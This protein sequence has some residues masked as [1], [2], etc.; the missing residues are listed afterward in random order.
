MSAPDWSKP[1]PKL[2]EGPCAI[3]QF[4]GELGIERGDWAQS[5]QMRA[6]CAREKDRRYV[7]TFLLEHFQLVVR[8]DRWQRS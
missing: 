8:C 1:S 6:W 5:E 7:P 3:E 4:A 2:P